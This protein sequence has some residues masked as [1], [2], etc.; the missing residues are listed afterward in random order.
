MAQRLTTRRTIG[1]LTTARNAGTAL[2]LVAAV[3]TA[4]LVHANQSSAVQGTQLVRGNKPGEWRYWGADAWSTRYSPLDQIN[5]SNFNALQ[6][7]WQW[8]GGVLGSD[9]YYRTTPIYANGRLFTVASTRRAAAALNP[10]TGEMLWK[11][12]LDE[13]IRWQK[14]PRQFAGRGLSYWTD[15]RDERVIVVTPGFHLASLDAKTGTPDPKFGKNGVVDLM[16]GLGLPLVPLAV[17][18]SGPLII[19]DAAPPRKAKPGEK[20]DPVKKIGADGTVGIDPALGQIANSSPAVVVGDVIVVGN[21]S[22]HGYYPIKTH[23]LPG[24]VRGFDIRTGKQ[25]WKFNLIPQPGE[26]GADSWKVST[27]VGTKGVG[28]VDPWATWSAD[29]EL[30]L[31]YVPTGMPLMDEYGGLRPG[32]NLFGNSLVAIDVKTGKRKWHFQMVHHDIWDYDTPMAPN[33]LDITVNGRRRKAIAQTTKQGWVYTFDRETGE[34]IW[35]MPETPVLQS[36]VPGEQTSKTQPIPSKPEPYSQQ[37]LVE[38]DLIDYTPAIKDSALK[39]AKRCRMGPYYIPGSSTDG[40]SQ[41]KC[42]W[43]APGAS[44]GV[45]IDGGAAVDPETG[46]LYVGSQTGMSTIQLQKDPCSQFPYSSIHDSCGL[47]GAEPPP[48]GY[49]PPKPGERVGGFEGRAN[50]SMI[51]GISIVKPKEYGGVT[52]YDMNSGDKKWWAPNVGMIPQTSKDALFSGVNLPPVGGRGQ[53]EIITTKSL[54]IYGPG[55]NGGVPG[56]PPELIALDKATGKQVGAVK[57]PARNTAVPMTFMHEGRQYIVFAMGGGDSPT[58]V[59]MVL[60]GAAGTGGRR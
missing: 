3:A 32:D 6:V 46:M 33:L 12:V 47:L 54:L 52:A 29:P 41:Y 60:P 42:S 17:D 55:R 20:W 27:K 51:G 36:D 14:A 53:A 15:G 7:A 38:A 35:P 8:N 58:L 48:P 26:F 57:I 28:K 40:K 34:P 59:A 56:R 19:S 39:L 25:L 11:W 22:I 9:E 31:V 45:N 37:G 10:A 44:G 49:T 5:A 50:G 24:Y 23:N 18:D 2:C 16:D 21:S 13:G 30:G 1:S 43:Y 4:L